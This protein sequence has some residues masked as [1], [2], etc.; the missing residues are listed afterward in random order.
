MKKEMYV[1]ELFEM[2]WVCSMPRKTPEEARMDAKNYIAGVLLARQGI[3]INPEHFGFDLEPPEI[4]AW[5]NQI[6]P[7]VD[8]S[9]NIGETY[10]VMLREDDN[11]GTWRRFHH[12]CFESGELQDLYNE[13]ITFGVNS[14][15]GLRAQAKDVDDEGIWKS[16]YGEISLLGAMI[17]IP[18]NI[19]TIGVKEEVLAI[20][21]LREFSSHCSHCNTPFSSKQTCLL[22][23]RAILV[24]ARCC[25]M[26]LWTSEKGVEAFLE[27][28][29]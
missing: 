27:E 24:P 23:E 9:D 25:N 4:N 19:Q 13:E 7:T 2:E 6:Y 8:V 29:E 3:A 16:K 28:W 18:K 15:G 10:S 17:P 1:C 26:M 11:L 20:I 14:I 12:E 5:K 21:P 22:M